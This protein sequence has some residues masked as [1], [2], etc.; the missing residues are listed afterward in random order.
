[1]DSALS[2]FDALN[3]R[4]GTGARSAQEDWLDDNSTAAENQWSTASTTFY[5]SD[6]PMHKQSQYQSLYKIHNGWGES[7]RRGTIRRSQ[8]INDA[9]TFADVLELPP[10]QRRRV[11]HISETTE[12]SN[13]GG[14]SYE[15]ILL[16]ICS[17]V[18]DEQL[19]LRLR[20]DEHGCESLENNRLILQD[21]FRDL[22]DVCGLGSSEL[23][24]IRQ[25]LREKTDYF[26]E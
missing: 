26:T 20:R 4:R 14:K 7:D 5:V 9:E 25:M 19:S 16:A 13:F 1:M 18:S 17:L 15:K 21:E 10:Y 8:I 11:I 24:R 2:L 22:M 12:V 3:R 6:A 23:R